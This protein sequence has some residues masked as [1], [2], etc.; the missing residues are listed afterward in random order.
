MQLMHLSVWNMEKCKVMHF[1][2]GN[3]NFSYAMGGVMRESEDEDIE[4]G[5]VVHNSL[6]CEKSVKFANKLRVVIAQW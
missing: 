6:K 1:G 5:V 4:L 2:Y 3:K